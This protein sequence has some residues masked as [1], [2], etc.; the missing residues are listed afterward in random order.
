[1]KEWLSGVLPTHA[2]CSV[3]WMSARDS[4][5]E[6]LSFLI[7]FSEDDLE[8][9]RHLGYA[10]TKKEM[11]LVYHGLP[12]IWFFS[13]G[14]NEVLGLLTVWAMLFWEGL[15]PTSISGCEQWR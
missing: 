1:M 15:S 2:T 9:A 14:K 8:G 6:G 12:D 3:G 13:N 10:L 5:V 7:S 11:V 4:M